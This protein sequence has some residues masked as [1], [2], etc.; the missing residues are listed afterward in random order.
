MCT[1]NVTKSNKSDN[2]YL[3]CDI[4]SHFMYFADGVVVSEHVEIKRTWL[5]PHPFPRADV[6]HSPPAG[7]NVIVPLT[8]MQQFGQRIIESPVEPQHQLK[9]WVGVKVDL[10]VRCVL[11]L[12]DQEAVAGE[13]GKR[14]SG[15]VT[16]DVVL[17]S[18]ADLLGKQV[19]LQVIV[20]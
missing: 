14:G 3:T 19:A 11:D 16:G 8:K 17:L 4:L 10:P 9:V 7:H 1:L 15:V 20:E 2:K 18:A 6:R 13:Y 5:F 12:L